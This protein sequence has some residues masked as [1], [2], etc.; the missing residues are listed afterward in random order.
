L[1]GAG[2]S[3]PSTPLALTKLVG[4]RHDLREG[5]LAGR[6]LLPLLEARG[7]D[8]RRHRGA[9]LLFRA[10][11][12][13]T[14]SVLSLLTARVPA[15][16]VNFEVHADPDAQEPREICRDVLTEARRLGIPAP[17]LE[18]AEPHFAVA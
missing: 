3:R 4:A 7:V 1:A 16:R 2:R 12:L 11:S 18:A 8:L 14:V 10:P 6:E 13:P 17:R 15:V 5:L 9:L